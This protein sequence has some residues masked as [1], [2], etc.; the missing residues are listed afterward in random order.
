M[1]HVTDDPGDDN[2]HEANRVLNVADHDLEQAADDLEY[3]SVRAREDGSPTWIRLQHAIELIHQAR[4]G[5]GRAAELVGW[6]L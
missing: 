5:V 6:P 3:A 1:T 2:E 4:V